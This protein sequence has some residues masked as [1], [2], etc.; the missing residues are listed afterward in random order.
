MNYLPSK[1][2]HEQVSVKLSN[3]TT[4]AISSHY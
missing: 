4:Y 1:N 2:I 3:E